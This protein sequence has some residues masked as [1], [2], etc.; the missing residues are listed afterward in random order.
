MDKETEN[1]ATMRIRL[2]VC[3]EHNSKE[4]DNGEIVVCDYDKIDDL[5]K[6]LNLGVSVINTNFKT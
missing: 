6:N 2:R 4:H 1:E 3:T 5:I